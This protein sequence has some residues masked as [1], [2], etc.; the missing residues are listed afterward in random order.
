MAEVVDDINSKLTVAL[1]PSRLSIVGESSRHAGHS[2]ARPEG[3]SHLR[4]E[5]VSDALALAMW[6]PEEDPA[7]ARG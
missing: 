1:T 2:G 7:T 4:I 6:T 3:E 5:V